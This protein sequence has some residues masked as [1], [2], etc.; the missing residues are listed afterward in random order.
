MLF[1]CSPWLLL[2]LFTHFLLLLTLSQRA[3]WGHSFTMC[4]AEDAV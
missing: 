2:L 4:H 3:A 1:N